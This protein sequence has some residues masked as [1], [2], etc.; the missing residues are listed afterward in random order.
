MRRPVP[1]ALRSSIVTAKQPASLS[2]IELLRA[3]DQARRVGEDRIR[4]ATFYDAHREEIRATDTCVAACE[5]GAG[6]T[7][8]N[9]RTVAVL[10]VNNQGRPEGP[11]IDLLA[12]V[13][14]NCGII[15]FFPARVMQ[16]PVA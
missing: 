7:T 6:D 5:C 1:A 11:G 9:H 15:R 14:K 12:L 13:C 3:S 10:G 16:L 2:L 4:A 8:F